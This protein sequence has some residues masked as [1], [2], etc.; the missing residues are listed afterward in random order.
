MLT[1]KNIVSNV[2]SIK[3]ITPFGEG[4]KALSFLPLCHSFERMVFYAYL[5]F[6]IHIYYAE[7]LEKIG[8]NMIEIKPYCFIVVNAGKSLR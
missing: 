3:E 5:S 6:G 8:E 1:H 7:N 4:E 2:K